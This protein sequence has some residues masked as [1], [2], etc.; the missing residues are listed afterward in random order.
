MTHGWLEMFEVHRG[1]YRISTDKKCLNIATVHR[2]LSASYWSPNVSRETV[3]LSIEHS[4]AFGVYLE[5]EQVGFA[6]V[7]TDR[8]TFAYLADVFIVEPH[9]G[10]GLGKWLVEA[11]LAHP[12]LQGLRRWMLRTRDA[13]SLYEQFGFTSPSDVSSI[14]ERTS[15]NRC[16]APLVSLDV[17]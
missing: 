3:E 14:M 16:C 5:G 15:A 4:L 10:K 2:F 7:I 6:R 12:E 8:A 17:G 13:H 9:R 1:K 11:I